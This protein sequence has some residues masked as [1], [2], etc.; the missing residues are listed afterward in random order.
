M[1]FALLVVFVGLISAGACRNKSGSSNEP[2]G[3][4]DD[5]RPVANAPLDE[6]DKIENP[7]Y[8]S[9][10]RFKVGTIVVQRSVTRDKS[11][12][13]ATVTT[14]TI[15]L[16]ERTDSHAVLEMQNHTKRYDGVEFDRPASRFTNWR[17][18]AAPPATGK[19]DAK[20]PAPLDEENLSIAGK[21]YRTRRHQTAD[22][23]EAG[24]VL[25]TTWT[26]DEIP[27]SLAKSILETPAIGKSTVLEVVE[28]RLPK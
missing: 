25:V 2:P 3:P 26:T 4:A 14:T 24:E 19:R 17:W 10:A 18:V 21:T 1:R 8:L 15:T 22:R 13:D 11:S 20:P 23:N 9:W 28:I 16:L 7:Q 12:A 27:G 6:R 5:E